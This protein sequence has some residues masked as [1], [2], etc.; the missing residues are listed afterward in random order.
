MYVV[1][2]PSVDAYNRWFALQQFYS[3]PNI[4]LDHEYLP[5]LDM[6][7]DENTSLSSDETNLENG[8]ESLHSEDGKRSDSPSHPSRAQQESEN[9]SHVPV[10]LCNTCQPH[11]EHVSN[12]QRLL[13]NN[14]NQN[15]F[16]DPFFA[17]YWPGTSTP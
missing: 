4:G 5:L 16:D 6:D 14:P 3:D 15:L 2:E 1:M 8:R 11:A 9:V 7:D 13:D 12:T 10:P 17:F